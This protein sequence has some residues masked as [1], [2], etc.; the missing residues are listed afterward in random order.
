MKRAILACSLLAA[1]FGSSTGP[2]L[3]AAGFKPEIKYAE[4]NGVK[5]AY[6]LRGTGKP[7]VMINGFLSS[8]SLLDPAL[9]ED[10]EKTHTLVLFD[11][12]GVGLSTDT[13][14]NNTTVPQMSAD[15]G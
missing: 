4:V 11:N 2:A 3:S 6:Y 15:G 1:A 10:L 8:M 14:E 9:L 5:L 13:V 12:R 7:L